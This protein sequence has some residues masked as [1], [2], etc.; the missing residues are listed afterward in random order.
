LF[1]K[2]TLPPSN[3]TDCAARAEQLQ[4]VEKSLVEWSVAKTEKDWNDWVHED[5]Q[6]SKKL[7]TQAENRKEIYVPVKLRTP[8]HS[9]SARSAPSFR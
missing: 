9:F 2:Y 1:G 7:L 3:F 5:T 6:I 4:R 8:S